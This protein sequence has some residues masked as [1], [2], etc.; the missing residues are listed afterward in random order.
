MDRYVGDATSSHESKPPVRV[1]TE[2]RT[3][4]AHLF[5][6]PPGVLLSFGE[7]ELRESVKKFFP[8]LK[9]SSLRA[10]MEGS[11]T[12][13]RQPM[14]VLVQ[15]R[16][17]VEM[18]LTLADVIETMR[19]D[20]VRCQQASTRKDI[21][22]L[23]M[24][25]ARAGKAKAAQEKADGSGHETDTPGGDA[26]ESGDAAGSTALAEGRDDCDGGADE[27][28]ESGVQRTDDSSGEQSVFADGAGEGVSD[29]ACKVQG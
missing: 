17:R 8:R 15:H 22:N 26:P 1:E 3:G 12:D 23:T 13:G 27:R 5:G 6:M 10:F 7:R 9:K 21:Q 28:V 24:A 16:R 11:L 29:G 25:K 14:T 20:M 2:M 19:D 18:I 4:L